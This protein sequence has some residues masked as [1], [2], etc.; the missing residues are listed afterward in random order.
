MT[1][2][3]EHGAQRGIQEEGR[4]GLDARSEDA[5]QNWTAVRISSSRRG[6]V[7]EGAR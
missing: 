4:N 2:G 5:Q 7:E 6:A 1:D 3:K